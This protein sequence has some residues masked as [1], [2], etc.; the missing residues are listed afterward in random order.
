MD[1]DMRREG[2]EEAVVADLGRVVQ[3]ADV[4][5]GVGDLGQLL[6]EALAGGLERLSL[7]GPQAS[8]VAGDLVDGVIDDSAR[9]G[10]L[11]R[12]RATGRGGS[13]RGA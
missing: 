9:R 13:C 8:A 12:G 2:R 1:L 7:E 11:G 4:A 6:A 10:G 5:L 3:V